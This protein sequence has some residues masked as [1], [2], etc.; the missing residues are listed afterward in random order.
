MTSNNNNLLCFLTTD[1]I[2]IFSAYIQLSLNIASQIT[3]LFIY[4]QTCAF[5]STGLRAFE[6]DYLKTIV[7]VTIVYWVT[8][9]W[10]LNSFI[11]PVS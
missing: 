9:V 4:C 1:V 5:L 8:S 7:K 2:E 11:F 10:I 3:I 6:Y